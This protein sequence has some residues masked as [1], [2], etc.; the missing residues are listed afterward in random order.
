MYR[1]AAYERSAS[2]SGVSIEDGA[3]GQVEAMRNGASRRIDDH[4]FSGILLALGVE[5]LGSVVDEDADV[6]MLREHQVGCFGRIQDHVGR[7][8]QE[9]LV[10]QP[11]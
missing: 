9:H 1:L 5:R 3:F 10:S 8:H 6:R 2:G 7:V 4:G 11:C